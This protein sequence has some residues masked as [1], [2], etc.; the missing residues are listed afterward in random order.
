MNSARQVGGSNNTVYAFAGA[1]LKPGL[2]RAFNYFGSNNQILAGDL[3]NPAN[4]GPGAIAGAI[5][6]SNHNLVTTI[7]QPHFGINIKTPLNP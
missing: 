6:V 5:G 2:S 7:K 1:G 4:G 3:A